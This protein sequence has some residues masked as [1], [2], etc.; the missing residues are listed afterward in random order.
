MFDS[1]QRKWRRLHFWI[2]RRRLEE[3]LEQELAFHLESKRRGSPGIEEHEIRKEM[4][5]LTLAKEASRDFW[6]FMSVESLLRDAR[7]AI[8]TLRRSPLFTSVAILSLALGIAGNTAIFSILSALLIR[9]LPYHEPDRLMRITQ[10]YPKAILSYFQDHSRTMDIAFVSPGSEFNLTGAGPAERITGSEVSA[11]FFEVMGVSVKRGRSFQVDDNRPGNDSVVV[12]SDKLWATRF[13]S[14][15]E[16][17]GK[18]IIL[19]GRNRRVIGIAGSEFAFPSSTV[20]FWIPT[21]I[22]PSNTEDYWGGEFAPLIARLRPQANELQARNEIH[23]L[24][25][26]IW[27][28]FPWPMP[29]HWNANATVISLQSDLASN[30]QSEL[31]ILLGAVGVVLLIACAN[32]ASLL[33]ARATARR[34]EMAMRAALGAGT[35]RIV[36]QL[37]IESLALAISAGASGLLLGSFALSLCRALFAANIPGV[38]QAAIDWRVCLF[39]TALSVLT[40]LVFGLV[41]ALSAAQVD[42]I[43]AMRSGSQRS[44]TKA[45]IGLRSGLIAGEIALTVVLVIGAS[46]LTKSLYK[47]AT[48]NPGFMTE[49]VL[50]VKISPNDSFCTNRQSCVAF[51]DRLLGQARSVR[52]VMDAALANTIPLDGQAPTLPVDVEDHPRTADFPSPMLWN[53]AVTQDYFRVMHIPLISG[54][55]F[56]TVDGSD[57]P[58]VLLISESTARRFWPGASPIGKHIRKTGEKSWRTVVGVVADVRQFDLANHSPG[59]ISGAM[60]MPY[61]QAIQGNG[62]IPVVMNLLVKSTAAVDSVRLDLHHVASSVNPEIPVGQVV[63][64][65]DTAENSIASFRS[66]I[67]VFLSFAGTALLLAAIGLYG[68]MS[69]LVAQRTYEISLRMAVGAS[70]RSVVEL[71]LAQAMRITGIGMSVGILAAL[72]FGRLLTSM[73]VGVGSADPVVFAS[74][75]GLIVF[76]ALTASAIPALRAARIDPIRT[77]RSE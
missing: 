19:S 34:K 69:Y 17:V 63:K 75:A 23:S 31:F 15:P 68:L 64:L 59:A 4:G 25:A 38:R 74:V 52:S 30:S 51:Y 16:L 43:D 33:L 20:Q 62:E 54:R 26:N 9:P 67:W 13:G 46:L 56:T 24:A 12:V 5:N 39:V 47:L 48:L 27:K 21:R 37:V 71:I 50:T 10:L 35:G 7:Y 14:D 6:G 61:S 60:Y 77:L 18:S 8:R 65:S 66:T 28:L 3:E 44:A 49:R 41:P 32:V 53:G 11:N 55:T 45:W 70:A 36:R 1:W 29:K 42:L 76:V 73:L 40:G 22:D 2:Q 58:A 57:A 72:I